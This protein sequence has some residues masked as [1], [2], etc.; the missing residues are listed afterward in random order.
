MDIEIPSINWPE[1]KNEDGIIIRT[2]EGASHC[3]NLCELNTRFEQNTPCGHCNGTEMPL[4]MG[5]GHPNKITH[6][7]HHRARENNEYERNPIDRKQTCPDALIPP[8]PRLIRILV[9]IHD[10][11][12]ASRLT[13]F[14]PPCRLWLKGRNL[15]KKSL[16]PWQVIPASGGF[17]DQAPVIVIATAVLAIALAIATPPACGFL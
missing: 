8:S 5:Q 7:C 2:Q 4:H 14:P 11:S 9:I 3:G 12:G 16:R 10:C 17:F 13:P 15:H 1:Y 6:T